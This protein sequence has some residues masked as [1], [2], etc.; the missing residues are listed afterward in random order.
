MYEAPSITVMGELHELTLGQF[1][2]RA[3]GNS[4]TVGNRGQGQGGV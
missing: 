3:D 2:S 4:G 1:F